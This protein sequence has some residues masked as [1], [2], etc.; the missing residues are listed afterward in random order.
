MVQTQLDFQLAFLDTEH[1][2]W[3]VCLAMVDERIFLH[4]ARIRMVDLFQFQY[5]FHRRQF[6]SHCVSESE[7]IPRVFFFSSSA[8][9]SIARSIETGRRR[10]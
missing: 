6:R 3:R 8:P 4:D 9:N 7:L 2:T 1:G 5:I 10:V